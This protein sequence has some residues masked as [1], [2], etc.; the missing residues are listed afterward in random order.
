MPRSS[1]YRILPATLVFC[2]LLSIGISGCSKSGVNSAPTPIAATAPT[3]Q[4]QSGFYVAMIN[5][6]VVDSEPAIELSV[7]EPLAS[8]QDFNKVIAVTDRSEERRVG[9]E[10]VQ[11]CRSRWSPYH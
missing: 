1:L 10:C 9:K 3:M 6:A 11:P 5:S 7:S 8:E 4:V 2:G